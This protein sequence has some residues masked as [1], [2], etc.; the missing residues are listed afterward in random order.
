MMVERCFM[1][2]ESSGCSLL[3]PN[4]PL[5]LSTRVDLFHPFLTDTRIGTGWEQFA[6]G[7]HAEGAAAPQ[8]VPSL[9][10]F[11]VSLVAM[12]VLQKSHTI[13]PTSEFAL[14]PAT[15]KIL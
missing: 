8:A 13:T 12:S 3:G 4:R 14:T 5:G 6:L 9:L 15:M 10:P 1:F 11:P 7:A 2:K